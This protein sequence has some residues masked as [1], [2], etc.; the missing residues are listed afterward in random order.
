MSEIV[1]ADEVARAFLA[2]SNRVASEVV[3]VMHRAGSNMK[4]DLR[5]EMS[6]S[7]HF[8]VITPAITYD[9]TGGTAFGGGFV[10][11][12]VGPVKGSPGSLANIA[13]FG[14]SRGGGTVADPAGALEREIDN[15]ERYLTDVIGEL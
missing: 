11:V 15:A 5:A 3:P 13:Y 4:R 1:G 7:Q 9:V 8:S 12:E 14:T 2:K 6:A 10:E